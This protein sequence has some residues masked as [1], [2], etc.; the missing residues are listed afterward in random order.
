V[1]TI[2]AASNV[3]AGNYTVQLTAIGGSVNES[4]YIG[5]QISS[6][7]GFSFTVNTPQITIHPG[8][9]GSV[10]T[11]SG[12]YT[13]GFNGQMSVSLSGF[14]AGTNYGVTG[15]TA[16]N[17][18]VNITYRITTSA[19]TPVGTIQLQSLLPEAASRMPLQYN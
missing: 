16:V 15:A 4:A 1:A 10:I 3:P 19:S 11:S 8:S 13:G 9:S 12:N 17:N 14:L 18:L 2:N 6:G 7:A 5:V